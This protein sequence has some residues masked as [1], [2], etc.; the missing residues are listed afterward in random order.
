MAA[1]SLGRLLSWQ[2]NVNRRAWR[3]RHALLASCVRYRSRRAA[4]W[5]R[6]V[7]D[8]AISR[9]ALS[10][11]A[12]DRMLA[13]AKRRRFDVLV[14]WRLDRL[15]RNLKHLITL[16]DDLHGVGVAFVSISTACSCVST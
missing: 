15:G 7:N 16:L 2:A 11:S 14:V 12:L 3:W 13:D 8:D 6:G 4:V 5:S 1:L 9:A 10:R